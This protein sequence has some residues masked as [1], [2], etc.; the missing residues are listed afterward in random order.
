MAAS[1][2]LEVSPGKGVGPS[3]WEAW[4]KSS[5]Q[6]MVVYDL[7]E[8]V[9]TCCS[10]GV[11]SAGFFFKHQQYLLYPVDFIYVYIYIYK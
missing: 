4:K 9:T 10:T 8:K 3:P 11:F 1:P 2:S 7:W 5:T 6:R